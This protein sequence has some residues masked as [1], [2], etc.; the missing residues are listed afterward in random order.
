MKRISNKSFSRDQKTPSKRLDVNWLEIKPVPLSKISFILLKSVHQSSYSS[1]VNLGHLAR[2]HRNESLSFPPNKQSFPLF[3]SIH[4]LWDLRWRNSVTETFSPMHTNT[5]LKFNHLLTDP[6]L[7]WA[8][9][10]SQARIQMYTQLY[11]AE[12]VATACYIVCTVKDNEAT[13]YNLKIH[14]ITPMFKFR[15]L[16]LLGWVFFTLSLQ[17]NFTWRK[18]PK[19]CIKASNP[20]LNID[21]MTGQQLDFFIRWR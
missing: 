13:F 18:P 11:Q 9:L 4:S 6:I 12:M 17:P 7:K 5:S 8:H 15:L 2:L 3:P 20:S 21:S 14:L 16:L 10:S 19:P 1:V